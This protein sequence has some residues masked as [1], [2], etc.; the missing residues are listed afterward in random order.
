MNIATCMDALVSYAMNTG[1]AESE[2]HVV[3]TNKLL[4]LLGLEDYAP[5]QEPLTE[6]LEEILAGMLE[7]A[8]VYKNTEEGRAAFLRFVDAVNA[9]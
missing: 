9:E 4:D 5:S 1:L 3:L 8:G 7:Y 6:D 2:D